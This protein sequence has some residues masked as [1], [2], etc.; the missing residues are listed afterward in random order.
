VPPRQGWSQAGSNSPRVP[1]PLNIPS[2]AAELPGR[3]TPPTGGQANSTY[4]EDVDP[5]FQDSTSRNAQP[6]LQGAPSYEDMHAGAGTRS[7]GA[8]SDKSNFTSISQRGVN[9]RWNAAPP[10]PGYGQ[11]P[12]PRRPVQQRQ[13]MLLNSNPDFQ[14]PGN[15]MGSPARGGGPQGPGMVPGSAYPTGPM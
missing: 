15:R 5:R 6:P 8:D 7:P 13:D 11:Q 12:V 14:L 4:Y 10:M 2:R 3:D 1:S 9:P